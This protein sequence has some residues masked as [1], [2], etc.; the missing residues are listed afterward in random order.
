MSILNDTYLKEQLITYIGNKRSLLPLIYE[1]L[2]IHK[3]ENSVFLDLFAGSGVVSRLGRLMGYQVISNDWEEYSRILGESHLRLSQ[4]D[5]PF[6]FGSSESLRDLLYQINNLPPVHDEKSYMARY[7]APSDKDPQNANYKI[8]RLFYTRENALRI[9]SIRNYIELHF[10]PQATGPDQSIRNLLIGLLLCECSKHTNTSGVF[11]AFHKGFGGHGQDA[12]SRILGPIILSYP[13]LPLDCPGADVY[14]RDANDLVKD[15]NLP[16]ADVA[17][18]DPPYNQHQ[19]G[20]NY[21]ILNT[22]ALWDK[23]PAPLDLNEKGEL[24]E[25]AAIR[26]DWIKTKSPYCY[27]ASASQAFSELMHDIRA[28]RILISYSNDGLIPFEMMMKICEKKGH[29]SIISNQYS[30]YRGGRQSN[31]RLHSNIEF[32]LAIDTEKKAQSRSRPKI[33]RLLLLRE[34]ALMEKRVYSLEKLSSYAQWVDKN[35]ISMKIKESDL[36]LKIKWDL[37]I[38]LETNLSGW[39]KT[40]LEKL[41]EILNLAACKTRDDELNEIYAVIKKKYSDEKSKTAPGLLRE[42]PRRIKMLAHKKTR[43]EYHCQLEK[44]ESLGKAVDIRG[45]DRQIEQIKIQAEKRFKE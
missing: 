24:K 21:H 16:M 5:I 44:L 1:A 2:N 11:K 42:V 3:K 29:I 31:N 33:R 41:L 19:Y 26:K 28:R 36:L 7:Y 27:K 10:P 38:T 9:D 8:E 4:K 45:I 15:K 18:L 40:K 35:Q 30:K 37:F 12:L 23:I 22:I 25:K 32:V 14:C 6:L 39:T 34:L 13:V 43:N 17:Y 20:S